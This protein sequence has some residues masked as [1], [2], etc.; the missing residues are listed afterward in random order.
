M[1]RDGK[2]SKNSWSS[3]VKIQ[4]HQLKMQP[5]AMC[6]KTERVMQISLKR[7]EEGITFPERFGCSDGQSFIN[8]SK[9]DQPKIY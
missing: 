1:R 9:R 4:G 2:Q 8:T 5:K 7:L 3:L 6:R